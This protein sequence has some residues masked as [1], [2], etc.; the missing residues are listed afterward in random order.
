MFY[1]QGNTLITSNKVGSVPLIISWTR[2][3]D[4]LEV[5]HYF[6]S[7]VISVGILAGSIPASIN[8]FSCSSDNRG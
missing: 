8:C 4:I 7:G 2:S 1:K 5:I 6:N 3:S